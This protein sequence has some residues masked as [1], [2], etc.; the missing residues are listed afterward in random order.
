MNKILI[1]L[2][3]ILTSPI[4]AQ[5]VM[6]PKY[7][8][9]N[10]ELRNVT[11]DY[12]MLI[13]DQTDNLKNKDHI[14][15]ILQNTL[16]YYY[17]KFNKSNSSHMKMYFSK[18]KVHK[19]VTFN[20]TA[21]D[22]LCTKNI[23]KNDTL[24]NYTEFEDNK[25]LG[26]GA[27]YA[28]E[29]GKLLKITTN[30]SEKNRKRNNYS[31]Y[32][33]GIQVTDYIFRDNLLLKI[34]NMAQ[35]AGAPRVNVDYLH[36]DKNTLE[37]KHIK[38]GNSIQILSLRKINTEEKN[39]FNY[40]YVRVEN[41]LV[42]NLDYNFLMNYV[43]KN[44]TEKITQE[45]DASGNLIYRQENDYIERKFYKND[46]ILAIKFYNKN[47]E[48]NSIVFKYNTQ[49]KIEVE[50]EMDK[51]GNPDKR[52]QNTYN[53]FGD[54]I[55]QKTQMFTDNKP[56]HTSIYSYE[57]KYDKYNNWIERKTSL[58]GE[59]SDLKIRTIEYNTL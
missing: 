54:L 13:E 55:T 59:P 52:I 19:Y 46:K 58:N 27:K 33:K 26:Y 1:L 11:N 48:N 24:I 4:V 47:I 9:Y 36:K 3:L 10:D 51:S 17:K 38:A 8:I 22:S 23:F 37:V 21:E 14:S 16:L 6:F 34:E 20:G 2:L 49:N 29:K 53:T 39:K 50:T 57:Y 25:D 40:S 35:A 45:F 31:K 42:D 18:G 43:E 28:I 7:P 41:L 30:Y 44:A 32:N 56:F 15:T 12:I 5:K